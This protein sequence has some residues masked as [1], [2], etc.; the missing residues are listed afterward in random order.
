M[1]LPEEITPGEELVSLALAVFGDDAVE[2]LAGAFASVA[3]EQE[4]DD[5]LNRLRIYVALGGTK[6]TQ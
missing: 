2:M 6:P 1:N 3:S 5:L 4:Y